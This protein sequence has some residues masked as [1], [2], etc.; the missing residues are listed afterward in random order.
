WGWGSGKAALEHLYDAGLLA[1]AGRRRFERLYDL[2][3]RVIPPSALEI[4]VP[5]QQ[6]MKELICKGA[7]ACGIGTVT[8][9]AGY[10]YVDGWR[11]RLPPGPRWE[12]RARPR[13]KPIGRELVRELVEEG[14]L[15]PVQVE[16]WKELAYMYPG[17][18]APRRA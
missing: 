4:A 2:V 17:A 18:K 12:P 3:E 5:R 15:V 7:Q 11:D 16:G 9:I 13:S 8:D 6:A 14:R 10:F 1:I